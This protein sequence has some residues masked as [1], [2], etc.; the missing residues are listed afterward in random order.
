[1]SFAYLLH[2]AD[3]PQPVSSDPQVFPAQTDDQTVIRH[4][5]GIR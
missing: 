3:L 2:V 5:I 1:M 4:S